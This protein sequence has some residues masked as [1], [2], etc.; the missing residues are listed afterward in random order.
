MKPVPAAPDDLTHRLR[1]QL[2]LAQVRIMELEDARDAQSTR[3]GSLEK[4]L[5]DAQ[6]LADSQ[7]D[8]AT[9]LERV[10]ADLQAQFE[11]LRHMQHV[12]NEALDAAR[13]ELASARQALADTRAAHDGLAQQLGRAQEEIVGLEHALR[14]AR[15]ELDQRSRQIAQLE[16]GQRALKASRS[17][18]WTGWLRT[19]E[20]AFGRRDA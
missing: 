19:L 17:W 12:T 3:L 4:L 13:H 14:A 20:R 2:I 9:H 15:D 8:T 18:R 16:A 11:H 5:A 10:R 1:Q 7:V 6:A